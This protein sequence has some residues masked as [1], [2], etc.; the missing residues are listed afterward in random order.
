MDVTG[1]I[2]TDGL[3][4]SADINFGDS[5]KARF[6]AGNDL[7]LYHD[8]SHSYIQENNSG[9][10]LYIQASNLRLGN[11]AG[12]ELYM[13]ANENAEVK[14]YYDASENLPPPAQA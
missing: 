12:S 7:E 8:G 10:N 13:Q 11:T 3:T 5:D 6:G 14:L 9:G 2:T 1:V 4:T